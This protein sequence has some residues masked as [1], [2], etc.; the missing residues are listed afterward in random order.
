M[1]RNGFTLI[2]LIIVVLVI[3][4]LIGLLLPAVQKV[5]QAAIRTRESN[6]LRQFALACHAFADA[7]DGRLPNA[8][9]VA[10]SVGESVFQSLFPYLEM[11]SF[12]EPP[13]T[14]DGKPWRPSQVRSELDPSFSNSHGVPST[15][16][17][18]IGGD[19]EPEGDSSYAFNQLV[20][21]RGSTL[22]ASIPDG[23]SQTIA[24]TTHYARCGRTPFSWQM[25][26]PTCYAP[27]P[28]SGSQRV[29]CWTRPDLISH[30]STFADDDM[31]DAV[32]P[33][34]SKSGGLTA[35]TFQVLPQLLDCDYR[36]P[37]ALLTSGLLVARADGGVHVIRVSVDAANFWGAVSPAGGEVLGDAW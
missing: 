10:P 7:H 31:G 27:V 2:E 1:K 36:V 37:Q 14:L 21:S 18:G 28:P 25:A 35:K 29:P 4:I 8:L 19:T 34:V 16:F 9:G 13:T 20:F 33:G 30:A 26:N 15:P 5:R 17:N 11:G 24:L 3:A 32:P 22:T 6:K 23:T 12:G